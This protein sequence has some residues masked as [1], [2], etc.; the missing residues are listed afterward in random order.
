MLHKLNFYILVTFT[1]L[2][3]ICILHSCIKIFIALLYYILELYYNFLYYIT[4]SCITVLF[5]H[6][7]YITCLLH[8]RVF[9]IQFLHSFYILMLEPKNKIR[10][11]FICYHW[12]NNSLHSYWII[13]WFYCIIQQRIIKVL[14][15]YIKLEILFII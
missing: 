10:I 3:Y 13:D 15:I 7:C 5:F 8:L 11:A 1:F 12:I 9:F 2:Y 6:S 14:I 4:L